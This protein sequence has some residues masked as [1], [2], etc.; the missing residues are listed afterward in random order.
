M[1]RPFA[2]K[3]TQRP[4]NCSAPRDFQ[5]T[6]I[7]RGATAEEKRAVHQDD[8]ARLQQGGYAESCQARSLH[9]EIEILSEQISA[10]QDLQRQVTCDGIVLRVKADGNCL[11]S[12]VADALAAATNATPKP[13]NEMRAG[14]VAALYQ[15]PDSSVVSSGI[16]DLANKMTPEGA[17][18][19]GD[20]RVNAALAYTENAN[21]TVVMQGAG[22]GVADVYRAET[23]R[24]IL[25]LPLLK[26][27]IGAPV[28][29]VIVHR[30]SAPRHYNPVIPYSALPVSCKNDESGESDDD[31]EGD[32]DEEHEGIGGG[33]DV[34]CGDGEDSDDD[35]DDVD[36][37]D[38]DVDD[39]VDGGGHAKGSPLDNTAGH[40]SH[41]QLPKNPVEIGNQAPV[42]ADDGSDDD[43]ETD[44]SDNDD[45]D[46]PASFFSL[47]E[48][49]RPTK[50]AFTHA[51]TPGSEEWNTR[52]RRE[53]TKKR[54]E[55]ELSR[56][57]HLEFLA[58]STDMTP[59]SCVNCHS[60]AV[61][62]CR[63]CDPKGVHFC[64]TCD[65]KQHGFVA[66]H[67]RDTFD[68]STGGYAACPSKPRTWTLRCRG[69][70]PPISTSA[71]RTSPSDSLDS[72]VLQSK[73][74]M[75]YLQT[76]NSGIVH[77]TIE[78]IC[79]H[80]ACIR[81]PRAA[82]FGC[83]AGC[84]SMWFENSILENQQEIYNASGYSLSMNARLAAIKAG[85]SR[86]GVPYAPTTAQLKAATDIYRRLSVETSLLVPSE[87]IDQ[88]LCPACALK[89]KGRHYDGCHK[90]RV[91]R[92]N[93]LSR[94]P[95][96]LDNLS[97][98]LGELSFDPQSRKAEHAK[99]QRFLQWREKNC[100]GISAAAQTDL[101]DCHALR[102]AGQSP[103]MLERYAQIGVY[104]GCCRHGVFSGLSMLGVKGEG[105]SFLHFLLSEALHLAHLRVNEPVF[106]PVPADL[107]PHPEIVYTDNT[108][109]LKPYLKKRD[110][111]LL[112]HFQFCLGKVHEN[113]HVC[114][115]QNTARGVIGSANSSGEMA[116][117]FW[118]CIEGMAS[119]LENSSLVTAHDNMNYAIAIEN[120][121]TIA[122]TPKLISQCFERAHSE[123]FQYLSVLQELVGT[124]SQRGYLMSL[125]VVTSWQASLGVNAAESNA[126]PITR[127]ARLFGLVDEWENLTKLQT[128]LDAALKFGP[129]LQS[130]TSVLSRIATTKRNIDSLRLEMNGHHEDTRLPTFEEKNEFAAKKRWD[131]K[132]SIHEQEAKIYVLKGLMTR[133]RNHALL[134]AK[135]KAAAR[136]KTA[137]SLK[138]LEELK[139][140]L[141]RWTVSYI[142]T[143]DQDPPQLHVPLDLQLSVVS[144]FENIQR[145]IEELS[146]C[147]SEME[148]FIQNCS[149]VSLALNSEADELRKSRSLAACGRAVVLARAAAQRQNWAELARNTKFVSAESASRD[150]KLGL[151]KIF[152]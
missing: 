135:E 10:D 42:D 96:L 37:D 74:T 101:P 102:A 4:L 122:N 86:R 27:G 32:G 52:R 48:G 59:P 97:A 39:D 105:L 130:D 126:P 9:G 140:D 43:T 100:G 129:I 66:V 138:R 33:L 91:R 113:A 114:A 30:T 73:K 6:N 103:T 54:A 5:S 40:L 41:H 18:E 123:A 149:S 80:E 23:A 119:T 93:H 8:L 45:T 146:L 78:S 1:K 136:R 84:P 144:A 87:K 3:K 36:S 64:S 20:N 92:R 82:E 24:E 26:P 58:F 11:F 31:E 134:H 118:P 34:G 49:L 152:P 104:G 35:D 79:P 70:P 67:N 125:S 89:C 60:T 75:V 124:I 55:V 47:A 121:K 133:G 115:P 106:G 56:E 51:A 71:A 120:Q 145:R 15:V 57:A 72:S 127:R 98:G 85:N 95:S 150:I 46:I 88:C 90:M 29:I 19:Y 111:E 151:D 13:Q 139:A 50:Q 143:H 21:I 44:D 12:S 25:G 142:T 68:S 69:S 62:R 99:F 117:K 65:E 2:R 116:E 110:P 28:D 132:K 61:F 94:S 81:E 112:N 53:E 16:K 38:G 128:A 147:E 77:V 22:R 137:K 109:L 131:L 17:Y 108:C 63:T 14:L 148:S 83:T 76:L 107:K 141:A 7:D